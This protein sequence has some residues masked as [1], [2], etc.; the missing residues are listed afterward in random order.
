LPRK[1]EDTK[2]DIRDVSD[3]AARVHPAAC[4]RF[5][6]LVA[7]ATDDGDHIDESHWDPFHK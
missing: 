4:A 3:Q 7:R 6:G 1:R 2:K 5:C